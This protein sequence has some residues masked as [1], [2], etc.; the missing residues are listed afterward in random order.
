MA[1]DDTGHQQTSGRVDLLQ[2]VALHECGRGIA[3]RGIGDD[4]ALY[5]HVAT[6]GDTFVD[7]PGVMNQYRSAIHIA[8]T[9]EHAVEAQAQHTEHSLAEN[10]CRHLA[11]AE[12]TVDKTRWAP[13]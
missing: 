8:D 9:F 7:Y 2:I 12:H 10:T 1:V 5:K 6:C 11:R 13:P 3:R 4:I